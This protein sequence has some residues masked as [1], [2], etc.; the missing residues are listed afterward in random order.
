MQPLKQVLHQIDE[1][2]TGRVSYHDFYLFLERTNPHML[3]AASSIFFTLD[4]RMDGEVRYKDILRVLY[5]H[6]LDK[7]LAEM[8][9]VVAEKKHIKGQNNLEQQMAELQDV[10]AVYDEDGTGQLEQAEFVE[11]IVSAGKSRIQ[12]YAHIGVGKACS[13]MLY[14]LCTICIRRVFCSNM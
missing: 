12:P 13:C 1:G 11:A 5:P 14:D 3:P 2:G 8:L 7:E 6:A 9:T 4:R 10:F